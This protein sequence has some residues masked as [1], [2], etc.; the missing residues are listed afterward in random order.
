MKK[1]ALVSFAAIV[2]LAAVPASAA[3]FTVHLTNGTAFDTRYQ[4]QHAS[5]D[6]QMVLILTDQGNWIGVLEAEIEKIAEQRVPTGYARRLDAVTLE[7]GYT[8]NDAA[9][10][11]DGTGEGGGEQGLGGDLGGQYDVLPFGGYLGPAEPVQFVNPSDLGSV[12]GIP[13]S[14]GAYGDPVQ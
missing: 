4:P 2:A 9:G 8:A 1:L 13:L 5:W 7:I 10:E 11:G 14:Y 3:L 6:D 12:G